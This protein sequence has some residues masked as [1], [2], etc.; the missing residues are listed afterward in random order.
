MTTILHIQTRRNHYKIDLI[1]FIKALTIITIMAAC[2]SLYIDFCRF[3]ESYCTTYNYQLKSDL[4]AGN[5]EAMEYYNRN[6]V[7]NGRL[8]YKEWFYNGY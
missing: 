8:L 4:A 6:Y 7:Q 1:Q 3:P 5:A 2:I